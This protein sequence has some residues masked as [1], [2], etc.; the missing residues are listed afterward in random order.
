MVGS[1]TNDVDTLGSA[2]CEETQKCRPSWA[3][4]KPALLLGRSYFH[5]VL[6]RLPAV[7]TRH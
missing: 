2:L 7:V 4:T 1:D 5:T 3:L 6:P